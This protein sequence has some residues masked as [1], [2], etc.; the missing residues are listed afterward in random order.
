MRVW[1]T[2]SLQTIQREFSDLGDAEDVTVIVVRLLVASV[3]G[4]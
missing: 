1:W 2:E 3:L 4:G